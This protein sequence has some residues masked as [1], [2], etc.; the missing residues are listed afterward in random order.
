MA[1]GST[2]GGSGPRQ[3]PGGVLTDADVQRI[4]TA[5]A[6]A[7]RSELGPAAGRAVRPSART[8]EHELIRADQQLSKSFGPVGRIGRHGEPSLTPPARP[9]RLVMLREGHRQSN[10][11]P[12]ELVSERVTNQHRSRAKP[13]SSSRIPLRD[14]VSG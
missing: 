9:K 6:I 12:P 5:V 11:N 14:R 1:Q 13:A 3:T 4:A 7:L 2:R 8:L 10:P